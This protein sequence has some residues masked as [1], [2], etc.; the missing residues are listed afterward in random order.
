M[1]TLS[2]GNSESTRAGATSPQRPGPLIIDTLHIPTIPVVRR[3][4]ET[5]RE[6]VRRLEEVEADLDPPP[7]YITSR[8]D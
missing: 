1:L 5:L 7:T 8:G 4:L 6:Q 3:E 2:D